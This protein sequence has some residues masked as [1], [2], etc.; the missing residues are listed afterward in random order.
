A[1]R[2]R[3]LILSL[4][5]NLGALAGFKYLGLITSGLGDLF[6]HERI[7][8]LEAALPIGISFY[9]FQSM[10]YSLDLYRRRIQPA[11]S[12]RDFA[13][14]VSMFPQ[15]IAGPIVR[16]ADLEPQLARRDHDTD[17]FASGVYLFVVGM[18]KKLLVAD[19]LAKISGPLFAQSDPGFCDAWIAMMLFSGQIY[20]DFSAYSDM[21]IGLGR[22]FGF[23]FPE[24]FRSPY[25][26]TSF[27]DFWRRWHI[28]LSS[29]L[30]DYLYIPLGGNRRGALRTYL[31]LLVTMLLGGLW[32][33]ASWNFML[34]GGVHGGLLA[35][36]RLCRGR[37]PAPP[38][39][40]RQIL[41]FL[42]VTAVWVPFKF[43]AFSQTVLWWGA[44]FGAAG[45]GSAS[46]VEVG[47]AALMLLLVWLPRR[48]YDW[49]LRFDLPQIAYVSALFISAILIGYG[50]VEISPFLYFRF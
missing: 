20:F 31:N 40:A 13:A 33:G 12:F 47:A 6:G 14:Y 42:A 35:L 25:R 17:Q 50:R 7:P 2:K 8:F 22:L 49:D 44:M 43:E 5:T 32:H 29:W 24:N 26:A 19:T 27:A 45:L 46:L 28:T 41:I 36:E 34:W 16:Y 3:W 9:T 10:S 38:K 15:L 21:A 23:E 11:R 39:I 1:A 48:V 30:R 18:A 37:I 4:V